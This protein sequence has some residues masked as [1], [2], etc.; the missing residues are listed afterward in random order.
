MK[1]WFIARISIL[2]AMFLL[3]SFGYA[4]EPLHENS[5]PCSLGFAA[6]FFFMTFLFVLTITASSRFIFKFE[7]DTRPWHKPSLSISPFQKNKP[8]QFWFFAGLMGLSM[9][10][11]LT[12]RLMVTG[13]GSWTNTIIC[14]SSSSGLVL[15][16]LSAVGIFRGSFHKSKIG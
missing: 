2:T 13:I 7:R 4:D 3:A 1:K 10:L 12:L 15:G 14:L 16:C 5:D 9:A 8:L 11:G 6:V